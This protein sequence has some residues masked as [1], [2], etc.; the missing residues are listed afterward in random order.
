MARGVGVVDRVTG[1]VVVGVGF[2][3][4]GVGLGEPACGG[5]V[6]AGAEFE[7]YGALPVGAW[8]TW[9]CGR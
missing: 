9:W 3:A 7:V 1:C 8:T 4:A 6:V 2:V 5:V